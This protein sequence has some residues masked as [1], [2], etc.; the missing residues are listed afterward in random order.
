MSL[1]EV[2]QFFGGNAG[3]NPPRNM[4]AYFKGSA[5]VPNIPQNSDALLSPPFKLTDF[6]NSGTTFYFVRA[7]AG[8][9]ASA[10][11]T[12]ASQSIGLR[13]TANGTRGWVIGYSPSMT[14]NTQYRFEVTALESID[15]VGQFDLPTITPST[16]AS[17]SVSNTFINVAATASQNT[18][19]NYR[20][21]IKIF[22]RSSYDNAIEVSHEFNY[23]LNFYGP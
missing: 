11:T 7:P 16:Y 22:A 17:W 8:D 23:S 15:G 3:F 6:L 12:S 4:L 13:W 18:E 10:D 1:N 20:G 5:F 19:N 21:R 2:I 14:N 9:S